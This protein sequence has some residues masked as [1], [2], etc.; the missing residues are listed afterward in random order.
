MKVLKPRDRYILQKRL[1]GIT[2]AELGKEMGV[3]KERIRQIANS[4]VKRIR[5]FLLVGK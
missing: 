1:E 2:L 3:S 5:E 4:A